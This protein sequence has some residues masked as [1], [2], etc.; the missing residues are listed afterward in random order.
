MS[1]HDETRSHSSASNADERNSSLFDELAEE[2]SSSATAQPRAHTPSGS[3]DSE[4]APSLSALADSIRD[5]R[6]ESDEGPSV[7]R[8]SS[9]F[10]FDE[11]DADASS[12]SGGF[13][14]SVDSAVEF[15][16]EDSNVLL[17]GPTTCEAAFH[18]CE[19]LMVPEPTSE[20]TTH[21]RLSVFIDTPLDAQ[22]DIL[23]NTRREGVEQQ[24]LIDARRF[25]S[26]DLVGDYD[27]RVDVLKVISPRDL[28]RIGILTTK[29]LVGCADDEIPVTVCF[30]SLSN[31][32]NAVN[33]DQRVF[34]F[35][36]ILLERI[37]A[38]GGRAH[39]HLDPTS[40]DEQTVRTFFS[41]F[42]A[43]LEFD[44][45]GSVTRR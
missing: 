39:F 3:T 17:V 37:R 21:R 19:R 8:P 42:D 31:L 5:R 2:V 10:S 41:L 35:L 20:G 14:A 34:Q 9:V 16:S 6:P 22:L 27:A 40:H 30:Y 4:T 13:D 7:E 36:H 23:R 26:A 15:A 33:D 32:I 12:A 45:D 43:V 24:T 11:T 29:V 1:G 44:G 18:C 28:R 38:A 25:T